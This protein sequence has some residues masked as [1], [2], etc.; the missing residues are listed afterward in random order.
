[1]TAACILPF[2]Q[3]TVFKSECSLLYISPKN[4]CARLYI[5]YKWR[6]C[7]RINSVEKKI[8]IFYYFVLKYKIG[9]N[10]TTI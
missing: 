1:M 6:A 4:T 7:A 3:R 5:I 2:L 8:C 10:A 9:K